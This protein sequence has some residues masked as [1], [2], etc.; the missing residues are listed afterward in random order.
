MTELFIFHFSVPAAGLL[1]G[2]ISSALLWMPRA[3][4]KSGADQRIT[5]SLRDAWPRPLRFVPGSM[6]FTDFYCLQ[7]DPVQI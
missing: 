5:F 7:T 6:T 4:A 2:R 1:H 3:R